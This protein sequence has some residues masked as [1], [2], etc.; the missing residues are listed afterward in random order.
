MFSVI[1]AV[2][3]KIK[4][5]RAVTDNLSATSSKDNQ[6]EDNAKCLNRIFGVCW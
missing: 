5:K 3:T 2:H 6:V 4:F 1:L